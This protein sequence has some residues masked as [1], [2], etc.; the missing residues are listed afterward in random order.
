MA[1][2]NTSA[3]DRN[4]YFGGWFDANRDCQNT[5]HEVLIAEGTGVRLNSSSCTVASGTWRS[6]YDGK[7]YS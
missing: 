7:T 6:F 2:E 3:Y 4:T 1:A 5:R